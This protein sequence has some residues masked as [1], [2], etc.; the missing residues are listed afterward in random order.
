MGLGLD[1]ECATM[2][3]LC[4]CG[5]GQKQLYGSCVKCFMKLHPENAYKIAMFV[6]K[7]EDRARRL[8][9]EVIGDG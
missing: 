6:L 8:V 7:N 2:S 4:I 3:R 5:I 1:C 9:K